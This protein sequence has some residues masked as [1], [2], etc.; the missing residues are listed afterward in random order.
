MI[1][2]LVANAPGLEAFGI[3]ATLTLATTVPDT[4]MVGA[5]R[6][7]VWRLSGESVNNWVLRTVA[8]T[9]SDTALV[10]AFYAAVMRLVVESISR[11]YELARH[12]FNP[13]S[14]RTCACALEDTAQLGTS[15]Y[16]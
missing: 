14:G 9:A 12:T 15:V 5:F 3:A 13:S 10:R 8:A 6:T 7:M 4:A 1:G 11:V 16:V 2:S